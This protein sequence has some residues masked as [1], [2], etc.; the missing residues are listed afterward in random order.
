MNLNN[1]HINQFKKDGYFVYE[2]LINLKACEK[3]NRI[4]HKL[5]KNKKAFSELDLNFPF[6]KMDKNKKV[7]PITSLKQ[8]NLV[9]GLIKLDK[10]LKIGEFL[11]EQKLKVWYKKFY[12][13]HAF[14]GDNEVYHQDYFYHKKKGLNVKNYLQCFIAFHDHNISGGCLRVFKGSHKLGLVKHENIMTR[15]GISK[16]TIPEF[17]S[18]TLNDVEVTNNGTIDTPENTTQAN[19]LNSNQQDSTQVQNNETVK[20]TATTDTNTFSNLSEDSPELNSA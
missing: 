3:I 7:I 1:K 20:N 12:P 6:S 16:F 18:N 8:N 14:D 2:N 5:N 15:N 17:S 19:E 13:K 11:T 4:I 9:N 10:I